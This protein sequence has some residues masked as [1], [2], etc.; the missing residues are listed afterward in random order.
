MPGIRKKKRERKDLTLG[1]EL[2][3]LL[4]IQTTIRD[5]ITSSAS[6]K[7]RPKRKKKTAI[8]Q[9]I[10]NSSVRLGMRINLLNIWSF[11]GNVQ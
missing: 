3:T 1:P 2:L 6:K 4:I 5:L 11:T 10:V 7:R 8:S 9:N